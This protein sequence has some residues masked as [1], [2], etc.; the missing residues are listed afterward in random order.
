MPRHLYFLPYPFMSVHTASLLSTI[1]KQ[2]EDGGDLIDIFLCPDRV[3]VCA[4]NPLGLKFKCYACNKTAIQTVNS[5]PKSVSVVSPSIDD[6]HLNTEVTRFHKVIEACSSL[7]QVKNLDFKSYPIG[8]AIVSS[9][10]SISRSSSF[11]RLEVDRLKAL[12]QSYIITVHYAENLFANN[13][14]KKLVIFNGR[15]ELT[16]AVISVAKKFEIDIKTMEVTG[17]ASRLID[18]GLLGPFSIKAASK[19]MDDLWS[20]P[21]SHD[22]LEAEEFFINRRNGVRTN[23][24]SFTANQTSKLLPPGW[25]KDQFNIVIFGSSMDEFYSISSEWEFSFF[26]NQ[27]EGVT[28]VFNASSIIS[29]R[30]IYYRMHP[31]L[32]LLR[33]PDI[34]EEKS[35]NDY[36]GLDVILPGQA[37]DTYELLDN[38]DLVI[39]FGS[40]IGI[41]S[42]YWGKPQLMIGKSFYMNQPGIG[43]IKT[44]DDLEQFFSGLDRDSNVLGGYIAPI[45]TALKYSNYLMKR[46]YEDNS[47]SLNQPNAS[48]NGVIVG[49]NG[50]NKFLIKISG[51][52]EIFYSKNSFFIYLRRRSPKLANIL[53]KIGTIL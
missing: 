43:V 11:G 28:R 47:F 44:L 45:D 35:L 25:E 30:K 33:S 37:V 50:F 49:A 23:D 46:G 39:T 48:L 16:N 52:F 38:A 7:I 21:D 8:Y 42:V 6:E 34:E 24:Q 5:L 4:F 3:N 13:T 26:Q 9:L 17:V 1:Y 12:A 14:Y 19:E 53:G 29:D 41:E 10:V 20:K 2:N 31:N 40:T 18:F 15:F 36:K 22:K 51:F 27:A 32:N